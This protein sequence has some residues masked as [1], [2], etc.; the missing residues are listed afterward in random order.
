MDWQKFLDKAE[1]QRF[2]P[3]DSMIVS[4]IMHP[5][6]ALARGL[7]KLGENIQTAGNPYS[8]PDEAVKAAL[9]IAGLAQT[10]AL[11]F[12]PSGAGT[13]GTITKP[14]NL[15]AGLLAKYL[16]EGHLGYEDLGKYEKNALKMEKT[17]GQKFNVENAQANPNYEEYKSQFDTPFFHGTERI[18]RLLAKEGLDPKRATSGPMPY[19]TDSPEIASNY[20]KN[21]NRR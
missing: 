16:Q 13:L 21:K 8:T 18:D 19:G 5:Q 9:D 6:E 2:G 14:K 4:S 20:A 15:N 7:R 17:G 3:N 10:G 12:A 1:A 11:P